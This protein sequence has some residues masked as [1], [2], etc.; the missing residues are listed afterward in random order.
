MEW[1]GFALAFSVMILGFVIGILH[2]GFF[3]VLKYEID[4]NYNLDLGM[5]AQN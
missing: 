4:V 1:N 5:S 2:C 3:Q